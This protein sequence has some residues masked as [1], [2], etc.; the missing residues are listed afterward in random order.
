MSRRALIVLALLLTSCARSPAGPPLELRELLSPAP[1]G[2]AE[3]NLT[4]DAAGRVLL[5]WLQEVEGG[6]HALRFSAWD[7]ATWSP[8]ATI[9]QGTDWFV[10]WADFP[11][12]VSLDD[13]SLV[14]HWLRKTGSDPYA[15]A[16]VLAWSR[17]G[18]RTWG[19][20]LVPH[21]ASQTEHGF[22]SLVSLGGG[23]LLALWLDGRETGGGG[24]DGAGPMTLR[25]A[26]IRPDGTI[27]RSDLVDPRVCDC[28]Q[29]SATL[30]APGTVAVAY[31]DRSDGE[32]RDIS[33]SIFDGTR[34]SDSRPVHEDGWEIP[35]CPV[36]GPAI[37][38]QGR[39]I[40][41]AWYTEAGGT[42]RVHLA[43][44]QDGGG[45]FGPAR[46]VDLGQPL[47]RVDVALL[48]DGTPLVSWMEGTAS[49]A[50]IL[51]RSVPAEG[52]PGPILEV[53]PTS[54]A[55][56]SGFPQMVS[57]RDSLVVAWTEDGT[58]P[59]VRTARIVRP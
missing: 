55:R 50:R 9:A 23:R 16:V 42:P 1:P 39:R 19:E 22:V 57:S 47:G 13:R 11:S 43:L 46:Q 18:G 44:S 41:V 29:T 53:A 27:A 26:V 15:Y 25:A 35:G 21:D 28:C 34:W 54:G 32:V 40:A 38:A 14:A 56:S 20:P 33:V 45:T 6:A 10:N 30:A 37:A 36:N 5:S 59:R 52:E 7:G 24:H 48:G 3:P 49:A 51:V 58:P 8:A 12:V 31:R 2:S 4:V 17:D